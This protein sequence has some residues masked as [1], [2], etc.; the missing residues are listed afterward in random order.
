VCGRWRVDACSKY[1]K[2]SFETCGLQVR[3]GCRHSLTLA[4]NTSQVIPRVLHQIQNHCDTLLQNNNLQWKSLCSSFF[5]AFLRERFACRCHRPTISL[6]AMATESGLLNLIPD[7]HQLLCL[8]RFLRLN[9]C[10]ILFCGLNRGTFLV[11][12]VLTMIT[13]VVL[14]IVAT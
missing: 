6:L 12:C 4:L 8:E 14:A 11:L 10:N 5:S 9:N 1:L 13:H 3:L 2:A 7:S